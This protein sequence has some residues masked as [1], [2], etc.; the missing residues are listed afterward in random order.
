MKCLSIF[1]IING[2]SQPHHEEHTIG[3]ALSEIIQFRENGLQESI[4]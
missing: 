2:F 1:S 3:E 4:L